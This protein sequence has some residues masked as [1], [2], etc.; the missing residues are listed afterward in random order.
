MVVPSVD[1]VMI[2]ARRPLGLFLRRAL[3]APGTVGAVVP[4]GR[5]LVGALVAPVLERV[6]RPLAVL[7][8]GAG[9]GPVTR[10]L[11]QELRVGDRLD[12]VECDP[13][14]LPVLHDV[15]AGARCT[16]QV[17]GCRVED[18]PGGRR[19]DVVVSALPLTNFPV[20]GVRA[21][22]DRLD[23]LFAPGG[24]LVRFGYLGS[25]AA[26]VLVA[27][28]GEVARH[29]EVQRLLDVRGGSRRRVWANL[30]PAAVVRVQAPAG[31]W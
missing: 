9:T 13:A 12:V 23:A 24:T 19:Y 16:A 14:F 15:V 21:V 3:G 28:P 30:P 6:G 8:V 7:E 25:T 29:R 4:S 2:S 26:R 22:L 27:G 1:P 10:R 17:H 18:L 31:S 20:T 5:A 11:V